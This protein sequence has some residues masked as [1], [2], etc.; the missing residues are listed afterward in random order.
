[1]QTAFVEL[2]I[3]LLGNTWFCLDLWEE[4]DVS[5]SQRVMRKKILYAL[6]TLR[7]WKDLPLKNLKMPNFENQLL[8]FITIENFWPRPLF[9]FSNHW[10]LELKM[11]LESF[12]ITSVYL[13]DW[14]L[15]FMTVGLRWSSL[16]FIKSS[17]C[18]SI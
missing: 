17:T 10:H 13:Y 11:W 6:K 7:H 2:E 3:A 5:N 8:L 9:V 15:T 12:N 14:L 4:C 16:T 18:F 1:M